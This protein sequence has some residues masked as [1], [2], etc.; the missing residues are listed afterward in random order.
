MLNSEW[1]EQQIWSSSRVLFYKSFFKAKK[2]KA[3]SLQ[4]PQ[5]QG[6]LLL[7]RKAGKKKGRKGQKPTADAA[8]GYFNPSPFSKLTADGLQLPQQQ[9]TSRCRSKILRSSG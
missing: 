3:D 6:T 5:Q 8:S 4:L 7:R 2:L 9:G 1:G